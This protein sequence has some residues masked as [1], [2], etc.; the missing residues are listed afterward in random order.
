MSNA[1]ESSSASCADSVSHHNLAGRIT[2]PCLSNITCDSLGGSW[3]ALHLMHASL[4]SSQV[5]GAAHQRVLLPA[6][7]YRTHGGPVACIQ[8]PGCCRKGCVGPGAGPLLRSAGDVRGQYV[9]IL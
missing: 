2:L 4:D 9:I 1:L 8:S 3:L 6:D 7:P 5:S